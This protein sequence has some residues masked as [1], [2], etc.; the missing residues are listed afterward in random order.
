[1][2]GVILMCMKKVN[3]RERVQTSE[4]KIIPKNEVIFSEK[5]QTLYQDNKK[6][7]KRLYNSIEDN[8]LNMAFHLYPIYKKELYKIDGHTN[9]YDFAEENFELSRGTCCEFINICEKLCMKSRDG[10]IT[11]LKEKYKGYSISKL[12]ILTTINSKERKHFSPDMTVREMKSKKKELESSL[13]SKSDNA[14]KE[15]VHGEVELT[16]PSIFDRQFDS[17]D[18]LFALKDEF[19]EAWDNIK[20]QKQNAKLRIVIEGIEI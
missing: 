12:R 8:F 6:E 1:M 20:A 16:I 7:L 5:E 17:Y 3:S 2:K 19:S 18:E 13:L 4:P 15:L 10:R 14:E 9:I 11:G